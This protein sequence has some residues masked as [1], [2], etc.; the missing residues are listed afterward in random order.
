MEGL[1][2]T[3]SALNERTKRS[4]DGK[5]KLAVEKKESGQSCNRRDQNVNQEDFK[6]KFRAILGRDLRR[7]E[8]PM[9]RKGGGASRIKSESQG[10]NRESSRIVKRRAWKVP[11]L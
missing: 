5:K 4:S 6:K 9:R 11:I 8:H 7:D 10:R 1:E 2:K 3:K